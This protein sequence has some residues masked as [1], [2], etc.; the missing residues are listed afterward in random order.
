VTKA[1]LGPRL[2]RLREDH[3]MTQSAVARTL[4]VSASYYSQ[5]ESNQRPLT[6]ALI[7]RIAQSF[8]ID[9]Q[10]FSEEDEARL[11]I[12]VREALESCA[13]EEL[14]SPAELR[15]LVSN[16][17]QVARALVALHRRHRV[18]LERADALSSRVGERG[19]PS[20][21][22]LPLLPYEEVRDLFYQRHNYVAELDERAEKIAREAGLKPGDMSDGIV[23]RLAMHGV[24]VQVADTSRDTPQRRY[25]QA[26]KQLWLA[27]HLQAGQRAFQLATQ[28]GL[29]EAGELIDALVAESPLSNDEARRLARLGLAHHFAGALLMPYGLF[30]GRAEAL[31][32]DIDQLRREFS[33]GYETTCHRLST[34]QRPDAPGVP[35]F[36]IRVDRAGNVSKRQSAT[37]FHFSRVGG[38]CPLWNVYEAFAQPSRILRQVAQMPDGRCYLWI[39]RAVSHTQGGFGVPSKT[40]AIGLGCD[41]RHASRLIYARGLDLHD[42]AAA[43]PIGMGCKVCERPRCPQ[44]AFPAIGRTLDSDEHLARYEPYASR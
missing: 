29:I 24:S 30:L 41:L 31:Q 8:R 12:E 25:D 35:F 42:P 27:P 4:S 15:E 28:L 39:A 37:D 1:F 40:H 14:P 20:Q 3:G 19:D 13:P 16:T 2:K 5:L 34:L 23:Q 9:A 7:A 18:A 43:T 17:P 36:F 11:L 38:T 6:P 10:F 33:V 21:S 44:R 26:R 22:G 32:Y